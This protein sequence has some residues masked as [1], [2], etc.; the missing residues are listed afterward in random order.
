M[1]SNFSHPLRL[2][3]ISSITSSEYIF[4]DLEFPDHY[5]YTAK[6][7]DNILNQAD[8]LNC[9]VITTEKDYLR[10]E[11]MNLDKIKFIKSKLKI[12]DENKL[13]KIL[14]KKNEIN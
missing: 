4:K 10:I 8:N 1:G 5:N 13:I 12:I 7:L 6:D 9:K 14:L 3:L 2:F 11:N